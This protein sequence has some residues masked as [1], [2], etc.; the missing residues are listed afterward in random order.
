MNKMTLSLLLLAPFVVVGCGGGNDGR[1][2]VVSASGKVL[3]DDQPAGAGTLTLNPTGEG[4][5]RPVVGGVVNDDGSFSLTTYDPGDGAAP[6]DYSATYTKGGGGAGSTDP[7]EM[8]SM[9]SGPSTT[10]IT[11]SIPSEG[12]TSLELKFASKKQKKAKADAP[13]GTA[14]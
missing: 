4:D 14:P 11:V 12:S 8:M 10:E 5:A 13:L 7:S 9:M 3:V 2:D 1:V 6:G